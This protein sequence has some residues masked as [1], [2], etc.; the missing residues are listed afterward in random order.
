VTY[1]ANAQQSIW[2]LVSSAVF[3]QHTL[4][5]VRAGYISI[6]YCTSI[7]WLYT[8]RGRLCEA[9]LVRLQQMHRQQRGLH[10]GD[11]PNPWYLSLEII[12]YTLSAFLYENQPHAQY[13]KFI[14]FWDNTL[15]VSD[16]LSVHHQESKTVL[17]HQVYVQS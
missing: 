3:K 12:S 11:L 8:S 10:H 14:L 7:G 13:L 15:H 2:I 17:Q 9:Y 6:S 1:L 4:P 16:G 5:N